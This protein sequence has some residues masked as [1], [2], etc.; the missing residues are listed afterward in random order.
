M[1]SADRTLLN[2]IVLGRLY[3]ILGF[4]GLAKDTLKEAHS[5]LLSC[6]ERRK[7]LDPKDDKANAKG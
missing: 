4:R 1:G 2:R 7:S 3:M 5:I 6:A